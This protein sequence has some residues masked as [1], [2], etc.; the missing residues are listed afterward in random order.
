MPKMLVVQRDWFLNKQGTLKR[1]NLKSHTSIDPCRVNPEW[2][3]DWMVGCELTLNAS[4]FM[5][6]KLDNGKLYD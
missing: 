3:T 6:G 1:Y 5:N 4:R 2:K